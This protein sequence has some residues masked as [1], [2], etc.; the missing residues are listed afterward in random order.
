MTERHNTAFSLINDV[1]LLQL[2]LCSLFSPVCLERPIY[3]CRSLCQVETF[4][5]F[6]HFNAKKI[7]IICC[8]QLGQA[9]RAEC[10]HTGNTGL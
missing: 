10:R 3:P 4:N 2:F 5:T 9:V 6:N 1:L 7:I 8:R